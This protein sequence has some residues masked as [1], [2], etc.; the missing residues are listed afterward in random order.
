[1]T[2]RGLAIWVIVRSRS[3][4]TRIDPAF[5]SSRLRNSYE[6]LASLYLAKHELT[7]YINVPLVA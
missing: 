4:L 6:N 3:H 2:L 1:M 5:I 7:R